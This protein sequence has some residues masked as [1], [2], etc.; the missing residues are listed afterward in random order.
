MVAKMG[1]T[2]KGTVWLDAERTSPMRF[3]NI[4]KNR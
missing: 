4:G 3:I 1:K 2:E